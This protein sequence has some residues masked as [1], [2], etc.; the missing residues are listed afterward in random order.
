MKKKKIISEKLKFQKL[1]GAKSKILDKNFNIN[2][3][4]NISRGIIL[5]EYFKRN[6]NLLSKKKI[7]H[8]S[9]EPELKKFFQENKTKFNIE[10]Y[11]TNDPGKI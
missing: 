7:L 2:F 1:Y 5:V 8:F 6:I 11:F 9:P 3:K 4:T 10:E